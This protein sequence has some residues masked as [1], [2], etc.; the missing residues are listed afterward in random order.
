MAKQ[1]KKPKTKKKKKKAKKI[2]RHY[3]Y[4]A[5]VQ[6][7][8]SDL[9]FFRRIYRKANGKPFRL[10]RED[11]CGTAVLAREWVGRK[12]EN[13]AWGVDLD[14]ATLEWGDKHYAEAMGDSRAR[15]E[16]MC[17]DVREVSRPQVE[18]IAALNFSYSV[19]K[20]RKD[21]VSYFRKVRH[22]LLPGG[23][24]FLDA[25][26]GT[27]TMMEETDKRRI[28]SEKAFDGTRTPS[29]TYFWEQSRFNPVN[30]H[31]LCHIHFKLGNGKKIKRAF[32]YDWRLWMLPELHELMLEAGFRGTMV[33]GEGW[34]EEADE[35]DGKFRRRK[36]FD[37]EGAWV[38]YVV[39]LT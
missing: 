6:S 14:P 20:S 23:I 7:V 26:G 31:I 33:Y 39:G 10:L 11:F 32:S 30:H 25:W 27:E 38:T 36:R 37:N 29:F 5:A 22:S 19:F 28:D 34:D 15:L 2:D 17:N 13:K 16:L 1:P 18:V 8:E 9:A 21:L 24:F 12:A 4:T 3:L 35:A